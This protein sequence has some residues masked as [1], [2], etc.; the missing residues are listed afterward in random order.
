MVPTNKQPF[1]P[2]REH[3]SPEITL[4]TGVLISVIIDT[5]IFLS[6]V[7]RA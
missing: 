1:L 6:A 7:E 3:K 5:K 2:L 4:A